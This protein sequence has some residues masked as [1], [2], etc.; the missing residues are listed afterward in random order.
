M[1]FC[2]RK[3]TLKSYCL[4]VHLYIAENLTYASISNKDPVE[5]SNSKC[6]PVGHRHVWTK[7]SH[8]SFGADISRISLL[9]KVLAF[10]HSGHKNSIIILIYNKKIKYLKT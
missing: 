4:F 9:R 8:S 3:Q 1:T 2:L 10:P 5:P 6:G 7:L